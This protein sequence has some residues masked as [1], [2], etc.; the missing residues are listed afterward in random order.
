MNIT[1]NMNYVN[2]NNVN[3]NNNTNDIDMNDDNNDNINNA[4]DINMNDDMNDID[5]NTNINDI[6]M[7]D[8]LNF[9]KLTIKEKEQ[10][11]PIINYIKQEYIIKMLDNAKKIKQA[12]YN[13]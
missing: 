5:M 8:N 13:Q 2:M 6:D 3:I 11:Y 1:N 10:Q 7:I 4:I 12:I 9:N